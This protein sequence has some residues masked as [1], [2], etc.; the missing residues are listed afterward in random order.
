M[1]LGNGWSNIDY[2][3]ETKPVVIESLNAV[4]FPVICCICY[5]TVMTKY[6]ASNNWEGFELIQ[7]GYDINV[8]IRNNI[9]YSHFYGSNQFKSYN[10]SSSNIVA[11]KH[12]SSVHI[13]VHITYII[14]FVSIVF[15]I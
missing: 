1:C 14:I 6:I 13:S 12:D 15:S 7:V 5:N 10:L 8:D 11:V 3:S 4:S 2:G 9:G